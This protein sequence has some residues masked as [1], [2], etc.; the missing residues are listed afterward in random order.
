MSGSNH[1]GIHF[2]RQ[3]FPKKCSSHP[4]TLTLTLVLREGVKKIDFFKEKVLN[5]W[6][7]GVKSPKLLKM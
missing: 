6:W 3:M 7:V 5:Y 1:P 4:S 2:E